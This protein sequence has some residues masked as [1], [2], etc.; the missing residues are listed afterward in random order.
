MQEGSSCRTAQACLERLSV[1]HLERDA[2]CLSSYKREGLETAWK[3]IHRGTA[4]D[5]M[6]TRMHYV[7]EPWEDTFMKC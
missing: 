2:P 1:T 7:L 5:I 6:G 3:P 4:Q